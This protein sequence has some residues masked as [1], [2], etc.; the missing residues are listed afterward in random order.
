MLAVNS[1]LALTFFAMYESKTDVMFGHYQGPPPWLF[2]FLACAL[3][4]MG[5]GLAHLL[6]RVLVRRAGVIQEVNGKHSWLLRSVAAIG[7]SIVFL[8]LGF[9]ILD[10]VSDIRHAIRN[11]PRYIEKQHGKP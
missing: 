5:T 1:G 2:T 4:G 10:G 7:W 11:M 3:L 9:M 6:R 8:I